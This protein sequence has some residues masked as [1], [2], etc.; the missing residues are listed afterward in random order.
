[1]NPYEILGVS[2]SATDD[3]VK[4]AYR[5]LC[6]KY[7]PDL[8]I[9]KPDAEQAEKKFMQVQQAY[10]T[11]MKQRQ[12]GGAQQDYAGGY[13]AGAGYNPFGGFGGGQD[14]AQNSA[15]YAAR[16]QAAVNYINMGRYQEALNVLSD[17]PDRNAQW[18]FLSAVAHWSLG[19]QLTALEHARTACRMEPGNMQYRQVL[20]QME[21]GG[22]VYSQTGQGYGRPNAGMGDWCMQLMMLNLCC[23]CCGGVPC[24][25]CC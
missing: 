16:M 23:N 13:G 1:M 25:P 5:A 20:S 12:G 2:P 4:R 9:G 17:I 21:S 15:P 6:K 18:F 10:E 24:V 7:H 3:E 22:Q 19:E 14:Y 11:I 8:H